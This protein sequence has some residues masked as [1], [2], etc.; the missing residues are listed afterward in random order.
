MLERTKK[1]LKVDGSRLQKEH[2]NSKSL[3][4]S[5]QIPPLSKAKAMRE[6][7]KNPK[8]SLSNGPSIL[9]HL[10]RRDSFT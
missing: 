7:P 10:S 1:N 2:Q 6:I 9:G 8:K 3:K 4:L 5:P